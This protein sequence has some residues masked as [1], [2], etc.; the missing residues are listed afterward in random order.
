MAHKKRKLKVQQNMIYNLWNSW[1][2]CQCF[3]GGES[4][5]EAASTFIEIFQILGLDLPKKFKI[6]QEDLTLKAMEMLE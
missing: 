2:S 6:D 3:E 5:Q 1:A 4:P